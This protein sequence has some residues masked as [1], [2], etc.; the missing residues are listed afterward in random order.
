[1][2]RAAAE[3]I[4]A[5]LPPSPESKYEFIECDVLLMKNVHALAADLL[6]RLPKIN[7]LVHCAGSLRF[8]GSRKETEEG[9][10]DMFAIRYYNRFALTKDLLPLLQN[11][12]ANKEAASV[13]C[14]L[15]AGLAPEIDL[16][17][18][19]LKK[20]Y[21]VM[22]AGS[23]TV[24]YNDLMVAVSTMLASSRGACLRCSNLQEFARQN[25]DIAF[26]HVWP[27]FVF[28]GTMFGP[29]KLTTF[30]SFFFRPLLWAFATP[31]EENA[32]YMLFA[33]LSGEKG[34]YRRGR[35]GEDIGMKKFPQAK[36]AQRILYE[37]S[38]AETASK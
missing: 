33:L 19:G 4:I 31:P 21:A 27:G 20:K 18:L 3:A 30:L 17:D 28:N 32:E 13:L 23:Q 12:T 8:F 15:G 24:A 38:V 14:V 9:I 5:G 22:K 26:T 6:K 2:N 25:P 35:K 10:D 7:F 37:H 34:M 11:A 36:D 29:G 1:R 16:E